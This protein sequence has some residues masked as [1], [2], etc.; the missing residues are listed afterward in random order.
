MVVIGVSLV[1]QSKSA[2]DSRPSY[3]PPPSADREVVDLHNYSPAPI[4][5]VLADP[6]PAPLS[7]LTSTENRNPRLNDSNI[8][9]FG[10]KV[11]QRQGLVH[12]F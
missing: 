11:L 2:A 9:T 5:I 7:A 12:L 3:L 10:K 1:E 4:C 6:V 8:S